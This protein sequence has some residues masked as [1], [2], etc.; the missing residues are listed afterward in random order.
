MDENYGKIKLSYYA[1]DGMNDAKGYYS[2]IVVGGEPNA[3]IEYQKN[4]EFITFYPSVVQTQL[5]F[6]AYQNVQEL[7]IML[8]SL[9]GELLSS[10]VWHSL[11]PGEQKQIDVSHLP[12]GFYILKAFT[13][14]NLQ[15]SKIIKPQ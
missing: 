5:Y 7:N 15:N 10:T 8:F 6:R 14:D 12:K 3:T 9:S 1:T 4:E 13:H 2:E 11:S